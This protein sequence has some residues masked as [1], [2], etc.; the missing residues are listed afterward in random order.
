MSEISLHYN[1]GDGPMAAA[2]TK[3]TREPRYVDLDINSLNVDYCRL[4]IFQTYLVAGGIDYNN[5]GRSSTEL[6]VETAAAWVF[7]GELPSLRAGLHGVN[8]DNKV[9]MTGNSL[10]V[11]LDI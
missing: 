5:V 10:T 4:L 3:T 7:T 1:R 9:L 11:K 6:L 2:T 8:I